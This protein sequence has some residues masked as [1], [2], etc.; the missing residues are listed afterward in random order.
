M[1]GINYPSNMFDRISGLK[2]Y[3]EEI[4]ENAS[5]LSKKIW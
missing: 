5:N 1:I 4:Y 2:D 3:A